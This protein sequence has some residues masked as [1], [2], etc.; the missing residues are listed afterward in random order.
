MVLVK[1]H[2]LLLCLRIALA[3]ELVPWLRQKVLYVINARR[4]TKGSWSVVQNAK[5][6][7]TVSPV[8]LTG[9]N[10]LSFYW[11]MSITKPR[12]FLLLPITPP[13]YWLIFSRVQVKLLLF[14]LAEFFNEP[15]FRVS[16]SSH[17]SF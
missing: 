16:L 5:E 1:E 10:K 17:I 6:S 11:I 9:R 15:S 13:L 4:M 8:L 12:A 3:R 2:S 14:C 7:V